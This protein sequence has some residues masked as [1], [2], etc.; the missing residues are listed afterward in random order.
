MNYR[1]LVVLIL[2]TLVAGALFAQEQRQAVPGPP[3]YPVVPAVSCPR[4][5]SQTLTAGP[6]TAPTL[7]PADFSGALGNAVAG[8]TWNQTNADKGFGHSFTLPSP[9]KECCIWTRATL[10][11]KVKALQA[12]PAGTNGVS[13]NDWVQLVKNGASVAGSGQQPF[14]GGATVGQTATVTIA[15]PQSVLNS[16]VVSLYVQDDTA[17]QSV[18]L[19][20]EG[21][22]LR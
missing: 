4:P 18:E 6:P 14:V 12:G 16:G 5:I 19:R 9:G 8:S 21:C 13:V 15:V 2:L 11:V 22:C 7:N 10:I 20:L 17:V 3:L 1:K